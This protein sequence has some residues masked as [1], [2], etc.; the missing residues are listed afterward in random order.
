M[1][2]GRLCEL[3][4]FAGKSRNEGQEIY[5]QCLFAKTSV[6]TTGEVKQS[7]EFPGFV[8]Y[9]FARGMEFL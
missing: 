5:K 2:L 1:A 4:G 7:S 9:F 8:F 6:K 3:F